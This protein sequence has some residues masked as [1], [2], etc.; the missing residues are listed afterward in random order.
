MI[1]NPVSS[2]RV[3]G[4]IP[5]MKLN[6]FSLEATAKAFEALASNLYSDK[7]GSIVRELASNAYDAHVENGNPQEPFSVHLPTADAPLS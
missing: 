5:N 6:S 2:A 3:A 1:I 7:I 4:N